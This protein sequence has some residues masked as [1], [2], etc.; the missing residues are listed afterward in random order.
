MT[1]SAP[2][3]DTSTFCAATPSGRLIGLDVGTKTIG[4]AVCDGERRIATAFS[5]VRRTKFMADVALIAKAC[6]DMAVTGLVVGLP[7]N[8]DDTEGP[9]AR[10]VRT[11]AFNL[12]R[13]IALP[14]LLEDER[15]STVAASEALIEAE[16]GQEKRAALI[17]KLAAAIILQGAL[18]RL[19][20]EA[21]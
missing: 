13:E 11:F 21:K 17:D 8:M 3:R 9:R 19:V 7:L 20:R 6:E 14:V 15:L 2:T 10:S 12:Q 1:M 4:L 16:V 5:L 18:D